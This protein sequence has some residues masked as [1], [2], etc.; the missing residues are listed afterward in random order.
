M[1]AM[2]RK[3]VPPPIP[4]G[5]T[6]T[7]EGQHGFYEYRPKTIKVKKSGLKEKGASVDR[8]PFTPATRRAPGTPGTPVP[9]TPVPG[10]AASSV[11]G[12]S[13][14]AAAS[15]P[16][17]TGLVELPDVPDF[18]VARPSPPRR[19]KE[20]LHRASFEDHLRETG[21]SYNNP[22]RALVRK[23]SEKMNVGDAL[24]RLT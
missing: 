23:L 7:P 22:G 21:E 3:H 13:A 14:A 12:S 24:A 6:S 5:A 20:S 9:G 18:P 11:L 19:E 15:A 16:A 10:V 17:A 2:Q 1:L 4:E 8:I